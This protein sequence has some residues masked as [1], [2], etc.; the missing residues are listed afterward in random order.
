MTPSL[1]PMRPLILCALTLAVT[2]LFAQTPAANAPGSVTGTWFGEF[3]MDKPDGTVAHDTAVL[4]LHQEGT[5]LTGSAGGSI[6]NQTPFTQGRMA[7]DTIQFHQDVAGG[8]D[9]TLHRATGRLTGE[10]I[11]KNL[12][13]SIDLTPAPELAPHDELVREI[14]AADEKVFR[15]FQACDVDA[16]GQFLLENLEFYQDRIGAKDKARTLTSMRQR[17]AEG[18]V[19]RREFDQ[20]SVVV[21]SVPGYGAI[22]AGV[23]RWYGVEKDGS[24]HLDATASFVNLWRKQDGAW[25]LES[26]ISYNHH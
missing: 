1:L 25:K 22:E 12:H 3:A 17:C 16:Y 7:G 14:L 26:V 5:T 24:Q 23:H 18:I 4:K 20:G 8:I 21:N 10:A 11:G 19:L 2:Q 13:A 6:D 9:F 15:A